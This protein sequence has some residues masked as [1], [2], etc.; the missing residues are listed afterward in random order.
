M[1]ALLVP[2]VGMGGGGSTANHALILT[3]RAPIKDITSRSS[4]ADITSR[5]SSAPFKETESG[6]QG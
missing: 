3:S 6:G 2:G 4:I 5:S 1:L